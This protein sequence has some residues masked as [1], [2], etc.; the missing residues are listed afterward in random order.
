MDF[1]FISV[2]A[3]LVGATGLL[4]RLCAALRPLP[5]GRS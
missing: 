1:L 3:V 2:L 4:I 5:R